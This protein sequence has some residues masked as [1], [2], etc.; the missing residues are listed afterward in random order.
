MLVIFKPNSYHFT[1]FKYHQIL[2]I[3]SIFMVIVLHSFFYKNIILHSFISKILFFFLVYY[4]FLRNYFLQY[5]DL[6]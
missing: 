4:N 3:S 5:F 2:I 1:I 6:L